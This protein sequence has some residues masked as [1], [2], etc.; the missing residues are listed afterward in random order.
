MANPGGKGLKAIAR[1][2]REGYLSVNPL[3][4]KAFTE[5]DLKGLHAE[6]EKCLAEI[7][8]E[9]FPHGDTGAI[10]ARSLRLQRLHGASMVLRNFARAKKIILA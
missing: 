9:K 1:D 10:R 6:F 5:E 2:V 4:L 3:F 8:A 7:R